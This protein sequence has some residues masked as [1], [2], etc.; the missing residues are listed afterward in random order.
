[1][2]S[3]ILL[4]AIALIFA[5]YFGFTGGGTPGGG[6]A[7]IAKVNGQNIPSGRFAQEVENQANFYRQL[8]QDK[9]SQDFRKVLEAQALQRLILGTLFAQEAHKLGLRITDVELADAIRSNP[10]FRRNGVFDENF[11]LKKFKPYYQRQN[12]QDFEY[13]LRED[14]LSQRFREVLEKATVVSDRQ[15]ANA[16]LV[17]DIKLNSLRLEIPLGT[18]EGD[19]SP[20]EAKKIAEEW[21]NAKKENKSTK[22]IL[23][24]NELKES[25]TGLKSL[26]ILQSYFGKEDSLPILNC[27][28][29]IEPKQVCDQP[30]KSGQN[31]LALAL[32]E[33][34]DTKPEEEKIFNMNRQISAAQKNQIFTGVSDLLIRQAKIE[35]FV[36]Q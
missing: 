2:F 21:I 16:I 27:L 15:V 14:L 19:F 31:L 23:K 3:K 8:G 13:T 34:E 22:S 6:T 12:G 28:L 10:T 9:A 26:L 30:H 25:E 1:M 36:N 24:D 7:P 18:G 32:M 29:K 11:Y 35:T 33:R 4:G 17:G 20:E 5:L